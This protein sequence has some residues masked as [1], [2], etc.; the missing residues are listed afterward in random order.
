MSRYEIAYLFG[1]LWQTVII[2]TR[3]ALLEVTYHVPSRPHSPKPVPYTIHRLY[4]LRLARLGLQLGAK[5]PHVNIDR[6]RAADEIIAPYTI[7]QRLAREYL[8]R[9]RREEGQQIELLGLERDYLVAPTN[10]APR[11]IN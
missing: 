4:I 6:A 7:K 9:V 10:A 3:V 5:P 2:T 11:A 1:H 8:L